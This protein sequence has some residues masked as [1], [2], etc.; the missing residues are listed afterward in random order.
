[1]KQLES[2][3][4]T[5]G[6]PQNSVGTSERTVQ[7]SHHSVYST[8]SNP[9][10][11]AC[12]SSADGQPIESAAGVLEGVANHVF[13]RLHEPEELI[14]LDCSESDISGDRAAEGSSAENSATASKAQVLSLICIHS[15]CIAKSVLPLAIWSHQE[16]PGLSVL[17]HL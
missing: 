14:L 1:M 2:T 7:E 5:R 16:M 13:R 3:S 8:Y 17:L 12:G 4:A 6:D 11:D 9:P 15:P 10:E